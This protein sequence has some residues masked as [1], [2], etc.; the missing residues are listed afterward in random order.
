MT[1]MVCVP[2]WQ[3]SG[4]D[5]WQ[6][7]WI[8]GYPNSARV[9]HH[10]WLHPVCQQWVESLQ[11]TLSEQDEPTVLVAHSLGCSTVVQWAAQASLPQLKRVKGAL[12]VAPPD[13]TCDAFKATV[14]AQ[15]FDPEPDR[16]L[17]FPS[18]V[19][20]S[21]NDPFCTQEQAQQLATTWGSEWVALGMVG[22]I[23]GESHL[24]DWHAGQKLLQRLMLA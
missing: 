10:D 20:A 22:H 12:L 1:A 9:Y 6:T 17:P 15:G 19:V 14:A 13:V 21:G 23:N 3:D 4:A 24:G 18:I 11:R 8:R 7:L 5:H 16:R 2:G